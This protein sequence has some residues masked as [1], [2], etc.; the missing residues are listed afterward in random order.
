MIESLYRV[1]GLRIN[2]DDIDP[3]QTIGAVTSYNVRDN[4]SVEREVTGGDIY[5]SK[6][7]LTSHDESY[8]LTS[9]NI[10]SVADI[11]GT[12][13]L[14]L[15]SDNTKNGAEF[16]LTRL[17]ACQPGASNAPNNIKYQSR[18][19]ADEVE[20]YGL[21]WP[22]TLSIPHNGNSTF[23]FT[24]TPLGKN[25]NAGIL[26]EKDVSLPDI[27]DNGN[28]FG[29][30]SLTIN[31][32]RFYGKQSVDINFGVS[33]I[34]ESA[35]GSTY[36]EW[37]NIDKVLSVITVRGIQPEWALDENIP[38]G[39][40]SFKHINT[41][42]IARKRNDSLTGYV[43]ESENEH[44]VINAAGKAFITDIAT[45]NEGSP[46]QTVL[47]LYVE[48]DGANAPLIMNTNSSASVDGGGPDDQGDDPIGPP[49]G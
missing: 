24:I 10:D 48:R 34:K 3:P 5:A 39:G 12:T 25:N 16:F 37:V 22:G 9:L 8:E 33:I 15:K 13:G 7:T 21:I 35:D 2:T 18:A 46:T 30:G 42:I 19:T 36:P 41:E 20:N 40:K 45:G 27:P 26:T 11:V 1:F 49:A 23:S 4:I 6:T 29:M 32:T 28:R 47:M 14:C 17:D 44:L 43:D 38:R 31:G